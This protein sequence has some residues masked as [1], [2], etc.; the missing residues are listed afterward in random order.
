[1]WTPPYVYSSFHHPA[2][3]SIILQK[4]TARHRKVALFLVVCRLAEN[5]PEGRLTS[6]TVPQRVAAGYAAS[7][8]KCAAVNNGFWI[9]STNV[10]KLLPLPG[11]D[12][13]NESA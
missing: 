10:H 11:A 5:A 12:F 8:R 1:M 13:Q 4:F 9:S 2:D 7:V 3:C 6:T